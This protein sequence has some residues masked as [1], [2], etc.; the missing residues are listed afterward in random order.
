MA[1][2]IAIGLTVVIAIVL[3]T[4]PEILLNTRDP[5]T[6]Q[7]NT[8]T[9][10]KR[11]IL[12]NHAGRLGNQF[13][14]D[15]VDETCFVWFVWIWVCWNSQAHEIDNCEN[16]TIEMETNETDTR[17]TVPSLTLA[18]HCAHANADYC[19]GH[20]TGPCADHCTGQCINH[21]TEAIAGHASIREPNQYKKTKMRKHKQT[22]ILNNQAGRLGNQFA[23]GMDVEDVV[24]GFVACVVVLC[25][26]FFLCCL[27]FRGFSRVGACGV[28][29]CEIATFDV[30][31]CEI[32]TREPVS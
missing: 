28:D 7:T 30:E 19:V 13:G 12:N 25:S 22:T 17:A 10:N 2:E 20:C 14:L 32:Y 23:P 8:N 4:V 1:I 6:Q 15:T 29:N 18:Y 11:T 3:T 24:L 26:V 21:C 16:E 5:R 27:F 31:T 9:Q